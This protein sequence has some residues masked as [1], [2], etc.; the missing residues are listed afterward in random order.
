MPI[1]EYVCIDCGETFELLRP[2]QQADDQA[3]CQSCG[4]ERTNRAISV[5]FAPSAEQRP[6]TGSACACGG[7]CSCA[8]LN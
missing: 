6:G 1:Y 2:M 3:T 5:F 8:S 7:A 4:G